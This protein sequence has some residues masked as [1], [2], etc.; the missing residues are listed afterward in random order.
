MLVRLV[1]SPIL[2]TFLYLC[3][4]AFL[5][6]FFIPLPTVLNVLICMLS[7]T[8]HPHCSKPDSI[9]LDPLIINSLLYIVPP[10]KLSKLSPCC[11]ISTVQQIFEEKVKKCNRCFIFY[12]TK[13][14]VA[15]PDPGSRNRYFFDPLIRDLGSTI[16]KCQ[17]RIWDPGSGIQDE[18]PRSFFRK[19]SNSF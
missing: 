11:K 6:V 19:P 2:S 1:K 12:I 5:F 16:E 15:D 4:S 10:E 14:S 8:L 17:I 9:S 3:I 13:S 7:C 18:N